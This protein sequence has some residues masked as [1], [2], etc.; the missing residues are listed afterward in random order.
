MAKRLRISHPWVLAGLMGLSLLTALSGQRLAGPLRRAARFIQIAPAD[1]GMYVVSWLRGGDRPSGTPRTAGGIRQL[2]ERLANAEYRAAYY[3]RLMV[4]Q[5]RRA[6]ELQ[7]FQDLFEPAAD[8]GCTL[9]PARVVADEGIGY[10]NGRALNVGHHGGAVR[11]DLVA[12]R[13]VVTD[14]SK[15]LLSKLAV[16]AGNVVVGRL[17]QTDA[18]TSQL[19]LVT[20]RTFRTPAV[21]TRDPS[22]HR[23]IPG[24]DADVVLTEENNYDIPCEVVGDGRG[25]MTIDHVKAD[26]VV[27]PGD[28]VWTEV[29]DT[30]EP[31]PVRLG[32]VADVTD[33]PANP[34]FSQL[35]V[36][37]AA[38]LSALR[39]V[40]IVC[41]LGRGGR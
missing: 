34:S 25:R 35:A 5:R 12:T 29:F 24:P 10:G 41:P 23:I 3:H 40:Y 8:L 39:N 11:G 13:R 16:L 38:D 31:V 37:P 30:A 28:V 26:D 15:A 7:N 20:H 22:R 33:D 21:I 36:E 9:I 27:L 14:R 2:E 18:Y 19:I 4:E 1:A 17:G 6:E 32:T